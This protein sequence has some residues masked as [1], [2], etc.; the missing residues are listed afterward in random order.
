M[1]EVL[2]SHR[3]IPSMISIEGVTVV[4]SLTYTQGAREGSPLKVFRF[5]L[6]IPNLGSNLKSIIYGTYNHNM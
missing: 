5:K 6:S 3:K 2:Q 4:N 1:V